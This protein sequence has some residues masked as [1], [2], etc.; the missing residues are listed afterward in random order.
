MPAHSVIGSKAV[1]LLQL[2]QIDRLLLRQELV[3]A[4][5]YPFQFG[6]APPEN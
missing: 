2:N 6:R 3:K 1:T 4:G 5:R